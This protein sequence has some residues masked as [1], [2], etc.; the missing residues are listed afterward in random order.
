MTGSLREFVRTVLSEGS[1]AS[2]KTTAQWWS[3]RGVTYKGSQAESPYYV[4][5]DP[6]GNVVQGNVTFPGDPYT[7]QDVGSGK[8]RVISGPTQRSVGAV[9]SRSSGD[10]GEKSGAADGDKQQIDN[11][12]KFSAQIVDAFAD[13]VKAV[14]ELEGLKTDFLSY[15][16]KLSATDIAQL[17][18]GLIGAFFQMLGSDLGSVNIKNSFTAS[19]KKSALKE[20][21]RSIAG[22]LNDPPEVI[23]GINDIAEESYVRGKLKSAQIKMLNSLK[24]LEKI[25]ISSLPDG[26]T[27]D[28]GAADEMVEF[29]TDVLSSPDVGDYFSA[30]IIRPGGGA[31]LRQ[32]TGARKPERLGDYSPAALR[33]E[34]EKLRSRLQSE[35]LTVP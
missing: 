18:A 20:V 12:K 30:N 5:T 3:E 27:S 33:S 16:E 9:I 28:F 25:D 23:R 4:M 26:S 21:L 15:Q 8:L 32:A 13:L 17:E 35:I 29:A 1:Q 19:S 24:I 22:Q 2:G 6:E 31:Y 10:S 14:A 11:V 7:Y 34:T